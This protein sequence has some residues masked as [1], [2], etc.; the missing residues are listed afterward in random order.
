MN[1]KEAQTSKSP[2][3]IKNRYN[4]KVIYSDPDAKT[5][6]EAVVK[7][8]AEGVSLSSADLS[9]AV[10]SSAVLSYADLS[11]AVLSSA[12]LSYADLSYAVLS[13]ADLSSADLSYAD[14]SYAV[15]RSADLRSADLRSAVLSSAVLSYAVLRSADLSSAVLSYAVLSS[16]VLSY[17]D[18]SYAVL[19]YADLRSAVL[20][21]AVLSYA[22]L[23]YAVLRYAVLSYADLSYAVLSYA[24]LSYAKGI[25]LNGHPKPLT[26]ADYLEIRDQFRKDFPDVPIVSSLDATICEIVNSGKGELDMSDWHHCKTTHCRAGWAIHLAGK[27]GYEL[28]KKL[29][30]ERA[31]G[32]IYL[33]STGRRPDFFAAT[34]TALK[35]ICEWGA[36]DSTAAELQK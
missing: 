12:D 28:E 11:S 7:A 22:D 2:I 26:D 30:P 29:G 4:G 14:L 15:L 31:G 36:K 3:E 25:D 23:S 8:V 6:K 5:L 16:A 9:S 1:E 19:S 10:L 32:M 27:P 20:R 24:V 35:D 18:L 13:Y 34:E 17:A 21:Y 33:A